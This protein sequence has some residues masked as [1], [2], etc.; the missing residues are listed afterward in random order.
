VSRL[1]P[2]LTALHRQL[3]SREPTR[4][5][6]PPGLE[7]YPVG[8]KLTPAG[9]TVDVLVTAAEG[10]AEVFDRLREVDFAP[11]TVAGRVATGGIRLDV[12]GRLADVGGDD[13]HIEAAAPVM[14]EL[15]RSV[16]EAWGPNGLPADLPRGGGVLIGLVDSGVDVTHPC[17]LDAAGQT[18]ILRLWDQ[19]LYPTPV[20][21]APSTPTQFRYGVEYQ[22]SDIDAHLNALSMSGQALPLVRH[23]DRTGHGTR[24]AGIAAG[25]GSAAPPGRYIGVAPDADLLVVAVD[26]PIVTLPTTRN[27]IDAL[28]YLFGLGEFLGRRLVVNL[29]LGGWRGPHDRTG[30]FEEATRALLQASDQRILVKS[31]GNTGP[32]GQHVAATAVAGGQVILSLQIPH[33]SGS[34]HIVELWYPLGAAFDCEV[35]DPAGTAS[36]VVAPNSNKHGT[37]GP[38]DYEITHTVN[39]AQAVDLN[40]ITIELSTNAR[41]VTPGRWTLVLTCTYSPSPGGSEVHAWVERARGQQP[42]F[43]TSSKDVTFTSPAATDEVI[44]AAAYSLAPVAGALWQDGGRGPARDGSAITLLTAPG[45]P[46]WTSVPVSPGSQPYGSY[47]GTSLAAPHVAGA[48]ALMLEAQPSATRARIIECLTTTARSDSHT[49]SG[50]QTA[51]GAG[52]LCI[53]DALAC[54]QTQNP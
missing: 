10:G 4:D 28:N 39:S 22:K 54:A 49:T 26:S 21:Q 17:F 18:R 53:E 51:W 44:V 40:Q 11:E 12:L 3:A 35:Y 14:P 30:Q 1:G 37:F 32:N 42:G 16:P 2:L 19:R 25:N 48:I 31:A 43:L 36:G 38:D 34:V 52:K 23:V 45:D 27:V 29:S 6:L 24:V 13:L 33:V 47:S 20:E 5:F 7:R 50:P 41:A 46:I 9:F 8:F 15:D